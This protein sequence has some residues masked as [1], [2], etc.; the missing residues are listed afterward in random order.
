MLEHK[1]NRS[2]LCK[3]CNAEIHVGEL[4]LQVK[5]GLVIPYQEEEAVE[6][7]QY[8]CPRKNCI[9]RFPPWTNI[10]HPLFIYLFISLL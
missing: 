1:V 6:R 9:V 3:S 2:A 7:T 8:F 10:R 5:G 4:A